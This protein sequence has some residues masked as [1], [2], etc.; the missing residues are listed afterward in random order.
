M[1][2]LQLSL[3]KNFNATRM[4]NRRKKQLAM[5]QE[6]QIGT[7]NAWKSTN[8]KQE[9]NFNRIE[10]LSHHNGFDESPAMPRTSLDLAKHQRDF[11]SDMASEQ[12]EKLRN[13]LSDAEASKKT[14]ITIKKFGEGKDFTSIWGGGASG[15][16]IN[17]LW[18][19]AS[20]ELTNKPGENSIWAVG[21]EEESKAAW[22]SATELKRFGNMRA[23]SALG[24]SRAFP[25]PRNKLVTNEQVLMMINRGMRADIAI[26][27]L[28]KEPDGRLEEL[29]W[30]D[31]SV[32]DACKDD[33]WKLAE[34]DKKR[35]VEVLGYKLYSEGKP[36]AYPVE[37]MEKTEQFSEVY[38]RDHSGEWDVLFES[39]D[40]YP[41][42]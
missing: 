38:L 19:S 33:E 13:M 40:G 2:Q 11:T 37:P 22:P 17:G 26:S 3:E 5:S 23:E 25:P 27:F 18:R 41:R 8:T 4:S 36:P 10:K 39:I 30:E 28:G 29:G 20:A 21:A 31:M 35:I 9:G 16:R 32:L 7:S 15:D 1:L 12:L 6:A 24:L 42:D 34:A 14:G